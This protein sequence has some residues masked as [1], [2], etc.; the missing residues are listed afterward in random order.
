MRNE[1]WIVS[2]VLPLSAPTAAQSTTALVSAT[3][4][5]TGGNEQSDEPSISADGRFVVFTGY[6][7]DLI[8]GGTNGLGDVFLRD[9]TT[10]A[11]EWIS[12]SSSGGQANAKSTTPSVSG[13]GRFVSFHSAATD[14]V[15][16]DATAK[17]DLFVRDRSTGQTQLVSVDDAGAQGDGDYRLPSL[18]A[19]GSCLLFA[20]NSTNLVSGDTNGHWDLF[21]R[22]LVAQTT[23]RVSFS[24]SGA[25]LAWG[26]FD[27]EG[28]WSISADGRYVVFG[29][30]NPTFH[31]IFRYDRQSDTTLQ[32]DVDPPQIGWLSWDSLLPEI[33]PDGGKVLY[34]GAYQSVNPFLYT[35]FVRDLVA[36]TTSFAALHPDGT[37]V[38]FTSIGFGTGQERPTMADGGR[39]ICFPSGSDLIVAGDGNA[40]VDLFVQDRFTR[41]TSRVSRT[42]DAGEANQDSFDPQASADGSRVVFWSHATNLVATP[43]VHKNVYV[44]YRTPDVPT[45]YCTAKVNSQGCTP[46]F[47]VVGSPSASS[48]QP[49]LIQ[50]SQVINQVNGLL[51]YGYG[52]AA[53]PFQEAYFCV[54]SPIRRTTVIHSGGNPPP[55]D[56]SG[57]FT[58]DF[59]AWIQSSG[60]PMLG[61]GGLVF[62]QVWYRDLQ[63]PVGERTGLSAGLEFVVGP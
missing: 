15:I 45:A 51:F 27:H 56:C 57:L 23:E 36:G 52:P 25:E 63:Y 19:D 55:D 11:T 31:H 60:D 22:D 7:T 24:V 26:Q 58:F 2:M 48:G 30:R 35:G 21:V 37:P 46:S 49:F 8:P 13:D 34:L 59:N 4:S 28:S 12:V 10:G 14:L 5:G 53:I 50:T 42:F 62:A 16:G 29:A 47:T 18:S 9:L 6:A 43:Q 20:S 38:S 33:T 32:V 3:T 39:L 41:V 54:K 61:P 17:A 40:K 1:L 44:H